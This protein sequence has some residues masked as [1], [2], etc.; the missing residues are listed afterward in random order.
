MPELEIDFN[1]FLQTAPPVV[2][3]KPDAP[4]FTIVT[5]NPAYLILTG[6][7]LADLTGMS[8]FEAFP[9]NAEDAGTSGRQTLYDCLFETINTQTGTALP[10]QRFHLY[11][12]EKQF[13]EAR[14]LQ[15]SVSPVFNN[16]G[17]IDYILLLIIAGTSDVSKQIKQDSTTLELPD[18]QSSQINELLQQA[19]VA[20][21]VLEGRELKITSANDMIL[22]LWGKTN[23]VI[24]KTLT[25]A[26]PELAGQPFLDLL[27]EVFST[28]KAYHGNEISAYLEH[29]GELQQMYFNF[30]YHPILDRAGKT[31]SIMVVAINVTEQVHA[32]KQAE[33]SALVLRDLVMTAHF[34]L[35]ILRG[36]EWI[37]EI[38]NQSIADLWGKE[39]ENI[40]GLPLMQILPELVDQPF[41]TLLKQVSDTGI[42]YGSEEESFYYNTLEGPVQKY[43]S[44][45]YDPMFDSSGKVCGIIVA[46]EDI[47]ARVKSRLD[48]EEAQ[49]QFRL[50]VESARMGTW[51]VDA[52]TR[53]LTLSDRAKEIFGLPVSSEV[54]ASEAIQLVDAEYHDLI[55]NA[56]NN[57]IQHYQPCDIEYSLMN[58]ITQERVWVRATGKMFFSAPEQPLHFSGV[59]QDITERK[60]DDIRKNDFIAM[61]SHELKTPLTSAKAYVQMLNAK[62]I[63]QNDIFTS[64]AMEKV[65]IQINRMQTMIKG[66]LDVARLEAGKIHLNMQSFRLNDLL[67]DAVDEAL[68]L[69]HS[70]DVIFF[71]G[72][73]VWVYADKD[74]VAQVVN[75][76]LSNAAKYSPKGKSIEVAYEVKD[77]YVEVSIK[78]EGMGIKQADR[79]KLF[80]RFYRVESKQTQ[81]IAGFGIGLYLCAEIIR[82]HNGDIWV[83]SEP[84]SGS[85]FYFSLPLQS[86]PISA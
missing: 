36:P 1:A 55:R 85:T 12:P 17:G 53:K 64:G 28:G 14:N 15:I 62:A 80:D 7:T 69:S 13:A 4:A 67:Q 11:K 73:E 9:E 54:S 25:Q 2:V 58:T 16:T 70:H 83:E 61:V 41:P 43:V 6:T 78:D 50:A 52:V 5:A 19:P 81:T 77:N 86:E 37:V 79:E 23:E 57:G 35:M 72:E 8:I 39:L 27:H 71:P 74:K 33:E 18:T 10:A 68:L 51:G 75:N 20:I 38:A 59:I 24:G 3:L 60:L 32:R 31:S 47:T 48:M 66:F 44:F 40:T 49:Q 22:S 65:D 26:L 76:F 45:F 63:R 21:G 82:R 34:S 30:V 46:A 84:G 56:V 42:N 29:K